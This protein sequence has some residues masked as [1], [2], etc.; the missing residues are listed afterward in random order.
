MN[1][2]F[3]ESYVIYLLNIFN[4]L[5]IEW[6]RIYIDKKMC[7]NSSS[8]KNSYRHNDNTSKKEKKKS[9]L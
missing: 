6:Y 1:F 8:K 4:S 3:A 7:E 2:V 9:S 5:C